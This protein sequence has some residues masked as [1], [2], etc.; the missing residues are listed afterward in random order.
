MKDSLQ[1]LDVNINVSNMTSIGLLKI[2]V[3][4]ICVGW[5]YVAR[6]GR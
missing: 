5:L 4:L 2:F 6:D 3:V 1:E